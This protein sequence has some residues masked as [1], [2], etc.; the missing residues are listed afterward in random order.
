M[1]NTENVEYFQ[2]LKKLAEKLQLS[3]ST[4][5]NAAGSL[6]FDNDASV[7]FIPS[8]SDLQKQYFLESSI[9]LLYTPS[10]EHFGIVPIEAMYSKT[11]VIAV[12]SGGP[13]E[14]ILNG[15]CGYLCDATGEDFA[16]KMLRVIQ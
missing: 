10:N 15:K 5:C 14:T 4:F 8:C 3:T 16:E 1:N 9:C 11:L 12:N 6:D 13:T 7:V 2:E